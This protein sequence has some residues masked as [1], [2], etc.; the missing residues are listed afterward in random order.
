[1]QFFVKVFPLD[2]QEA[3]EENI[4]SLRGTEVSR[5]LLEEFIV[6]DLSGKGKL[7]LGQI[8][9][10]MMIWL[11]SAQPSDEL[12][13]KIFERIRDGSNWKAFINILR[14]VREPLNQSASAD[15]QEASSVDPYNLLVRRFH[16]ALNE[17]YQINWQNFEDYISPHCFVYLVERFLILSFCPSGFFYTTKSSFLEW[18]IFQNPGVS[19]IAGFQTSCPSSEIFYNSVTSMVHWLLFHNLETA[20][21]IARSKI[22]SSNYHK[23]LVLRLVVILCLLC[24]NSSSQEPWIALFDALKS[25]YITSELPREFN[26][27]FR[28]GGKHTAFVDRVKIAE[29]LRVIGNPALFVD[30]KQNT[31]SSVCPNT[32]YLGIGPNSCRADIMEMLF[33]RKRVTSPV[34]KSMKNSC[35]LLPL[36][37]DLDIETSV[38]PSP[39]DASAQN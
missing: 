33:P 17:T 31:A 7:T 26:K 34:E 36:I 14:S 32:T 18:L 37:A 5:S 28:R 35:C 21:W 27:V 16:E 29:A 30:F 39:D 11:G 12:C 2:Y 38:L 25:P 6:N 22:Q 15:S 4:I 8:G 24:M 3:L 19:V 9:R 10:L 20:H 1:M 23:L 13:H